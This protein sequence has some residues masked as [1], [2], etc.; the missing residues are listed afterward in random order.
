MDTN[1]LTHFTNQLCKVITELNKGNFS[2][3]IKTD[4]NP[5]TNG[6]Y[7]ALNMFAENLDNKILFFN[8]LRPNSLYQFT[9]SYHFIFQS[10]FTLIN[11]SNSVQEAFPKIQVGNSLLNVIPLKEQDKFH[12][13]FEQLQQTNSNKIVFSLDILTNS[14]NYNTYATL[15]KTATDQYILSLARTIIHPEMLSEYAET[16][17]SLVSIS[18]VRPH[19]LECI[20]QVYD[21]INSK[22]FQHIKTIEQFSSLYGINISALQKGFKLLYQD[23][24]YQYYLKQRLEYANDLILNS[25]TSLKEIAFDSGFT[26]YSNFFKNYT[27]YFNRNPNKLR[28]NKKRK[29]K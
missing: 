8:F 27:K 7:Q 24:I 1:E 19:E 16:H 15:H 28:T 9:H 6:I 25:S 3:R 17:T 20:A 2:Y 29:P 5:V 26:N 23:S 11:Y 18:K 22:K 12:S 10:N 21:Y 4:N 14:K 13:N